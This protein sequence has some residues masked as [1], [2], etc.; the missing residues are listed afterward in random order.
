M[1]ITKEMRKIIEGAAEHLDATPKEVI[2]TLKYNCILEELIP[3]IEF[4]REQKKE[5]GK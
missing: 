5:V 2:E 1:R 3:Q 4:I